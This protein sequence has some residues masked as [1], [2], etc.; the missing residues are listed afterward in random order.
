M[1]VCARAGVHDREHGERAAAG[2]EGAGRGRR[3]PPRAAARR[4]RAARAGG[5]AAPAPR[6]L[7]RLRD[8]P[9]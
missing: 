1:C 9:R 5:R 4:Q 3:R 8:A 2:H 6:A 7:L